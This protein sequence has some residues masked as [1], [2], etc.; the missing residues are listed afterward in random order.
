VSIAQCVKE[1]RPCAACP[2]AAR[3]LVS[4]VQ[5]GATVP[6]CE[7]AY[8]ARFG[9]NVKQVD[10]RDSPAR[11]SAD[12][13]VTIAVWSDFG[14][15]ACKMAMPLLDEIFE[16]RAPDVRLVHKFYPL[17]QHPYSDGAARA[18][19]AAHKQGRYWEME[20]LLFANQQ[21]QAETDLMAHAASLKL[22]R[23]QF[24]ADMASDQAK[25]V[26]E[27]DKAQ[28]DKAG[29][30]GTPFIL[31]NGREFDTMLFRLDADLDE[32]VSLEIELAKASKGQDKKVEV[33]RPE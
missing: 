24:K 9:P 22:D 5:T 28:A 15:P 8:A 18:A 21:A 13:P 6:E 27:R 2:A 33:A 16:K 26:I 10:L 4:R 29:L 17:K 14:C 3:L 11:G 32:W 1:A 12:A 20:G 23:K 25:S 30:N 7:A 31:I 19:F